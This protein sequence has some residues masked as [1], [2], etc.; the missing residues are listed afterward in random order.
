MI[1]MMTIS[2]ARNMHRP[3]EVLEVLEQPVVLDPDHV[4]EDE[5]GDGQGEGRARIGGGRLDEVEE[6]EDVADEDEER[7][8]RR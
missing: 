7:Q 5:R 8:T 1:S 3:E 4:V 6:A 2:G